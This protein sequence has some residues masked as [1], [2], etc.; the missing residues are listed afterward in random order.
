MVRKLLK[1]L[2]SSKNSIYFEGLLLR[3][4]MP[5]FLDMEDCVWESATLP[6]EVCESFISGGG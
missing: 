4:L 3:D 1:S 2:N 6:T 5:L